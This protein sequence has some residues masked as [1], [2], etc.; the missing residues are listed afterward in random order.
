MKINK[1][2][3]III[4]TLTFLFI[5]IGVYTLMNRQEQGSQKE[6]NNKRLTEIVEKF[7][8][9]NVK[10]FLDGSNVE[11]KAKTS[12]STL[13][14]YYLEKDKYTFKLKN[15]ILESNELIDEATTGELLDTLLNLK[16]TS[17]YSFFGVFN[18]H[19]ALDYSLEED[20]LELTKEEKGYKLKVNL[21]KELVVKE[22]LDVTINAKDYNSDILNL[23][24]NRKD[25]YQ[26]GY[27]IYKEETDTKGNKVIT[28]AQYKDCNIENLRQSIANYLEVTKG[29]DTKEKFLS[30]VSIE[31]LE[32]QTFTRDNYVLN[33]T[34]LVSKEDITDECFN[35]YLS[36]NY[37]V[38]TL[39]VSGK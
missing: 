23:R 8:S 30:E 4:L 12:S 39:I 9:R 32:Q 6:E 11:M 28:F 5:L 38:V 1:K 3:F 21:N 20:G 33:S 15:N 24:Y 18:N 7:N 17:P 13:V 35:Y 10:V 37:R 34:Y 31:S 16:E 29:K 25:Y 26:K 19:T 2:M 22:Y 36:S 14:L 27:I